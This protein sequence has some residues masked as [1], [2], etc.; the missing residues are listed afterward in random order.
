MGV[1]FRRPR[2]SWWL[3]SEFRS[4]TGYEIVATVDGVRHATGP[5][6]C[7]RS[8]LVPWPFEPLGSRSSV[9]WQVRVR[10]GNTW[11]EWSP[12]DVF[13]TALLDPA[14]WSARFIGNPADDESL[15]GK[16]K[17]PAAYFRRSI[18]VGSTPS[19]ARIYATA[20]GL[21]ELHLDGQRIGDLELTPGFTAYR[22]HLE[23]QTYD[24]TALLQPGEHVLTATVSDGWWRGSVCFGHD[25]CCYGTHLALLLQLEIEANGHRLIVGT[26]DSWE[27]SE[28]GPIVAADLMEGQRVDQRLS[29]PPAAGWRPANLLGAA[30]DRLTV[31]PGP[32][33]RGITRTAPQSVAQVGP[34][35][36][37]VDVGQNING[38]LRLSGA[39]LGPAGNTVR[40]CHGE[41]L[42]EQGRLDTSHLDSVD[43]L[44]GEPIPLGQIDEVISAGTAEDFEPRH[45]THGFQYAGIEGVSRLEAS[46]VEAVAVHTDMER[47]GWFRCSDERLNRFHEIVVRSFEG[48]ACEIPTDCP[49]RE[50]AGWTGDW[51]LFVPS[52]AFLYDVAGFSWRWLRDL[53]AD[54]RA[55]GRVANFVPDPLNAG[56]H[57]D[58]PDQASAV[59]EYLIGSAGWGDAAVYVPYQ[60][61]QSYGDL[62]VLRRQW[63]SMTAWVDFAL[64][65]A[66]EQRHPAKVARH[67]EPA[68]HE[69]F[70]WDVG[71]HWGEWLEPNADAMPI[72]TGEVSAGDV[73][74]AYLYRSLSTVASIGRLLGEDEQAARYDELAGLVRAAW[75]A[76]FVSE[77]GHVEPATQ[78][79]LTRA[80][81]FG[82]VD[83]PHRHQVAADL[84]RLIRDAGT[85]VGTGFLATPF[86]LP[87]L[88]DCGHLD[89]AYELLLQ[90]KSPSWLHMVEAGATTVWENW[91]GLDRNG[92]G[93]LNHYS[94]GAV[95]SFLHEYVAGLRPVLGAPGYS[96][97]QVQPRPG[98]GLSSAEAVL[99]TPYGP[100]RSLWQ[101]DGNE[102]TLDIT[103][104]PG[105]S[106]EAILPSGRR[107]TL[108]PG[109]HRLIDPGAS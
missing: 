42:D 12:E 67:P 50:R 11:S 80:L 74:T 85:T 101:L 26:D 65:R 15:A 104:A 22:H 91:E 61:W 29:F 1:G 63:P 14:D 105:T 25:D 69:Q 32:P 34:Q 93:S 46:D 17:R 92:K 45:T 89:V 75:Q 60:I 90:T 6:A 58:S 81:A 33:A 95:I 97:F 41:S 57:T 47:T 52:A 108:G 73:A 96:R 82:L 100:I 98:G 23:Y 44:T 76:E 62:E 30:D 51:Q 64:R 2:L 35:Q 49:T 83:D 4:Q 66:R 79:N 24:V 38:W 43:P 31:S 59:Q 13:E 16:G 19:R 53:A 94:K 39:V 5:Q 10:S 18:S 106:A 68:A 9:T 54:Q 72:L 40:L 84:V 87:V 109:A 88:A 70:L 48:N 56:R 55:D 37:V 8:I 99:H 71:F 86:L 107:T 3:P 27:V 102:L 21:Y 78:A 7:D 20:H 28:Q 36:Y 103:V 77:D